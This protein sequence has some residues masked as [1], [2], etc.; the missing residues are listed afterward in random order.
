VGTLKSN[1]WGLYDMSGNV[2]EW[3]E[4]W[5][6]KEYPAGE[7]VDPKGVASGSFRVICGGSWYSNSQFCRSVTRYHLMPF[8]GSTYVGFRVVAVPVEGK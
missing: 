6:A 4:D 2:W 7:Q 3:C 8:C 5:Y 1:A